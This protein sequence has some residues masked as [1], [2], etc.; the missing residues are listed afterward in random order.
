M[1][2]RRTTQTT[3]QFYGLGFDQQTGPSSS[4]PW[5]LPQGRGWEIQIPVYMDRTMSGGFGA[6]NDCNTFLSKL[7]DGNDS[8]Q[9]F[10]RQGLFVNNAAP[11]GGGGGAPGTGA[12]DVGLQP[13]AQKP[14]PD[15][16]ATA[17]KKCK[18]GQKLKKGKC[19]KKK[20]K[21]KKSERAQA[22]L[23]CPP[24]P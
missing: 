9:L 8:P 7:L 5:P 4:Y 17:K 22:S 11:G 1:H 18:K 14:D 19:V 6:C 3:G 16:P 23:S 21:K 10:P 12:D 24:W 2:V 20:R 15:P 13:A